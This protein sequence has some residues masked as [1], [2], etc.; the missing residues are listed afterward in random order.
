MQVFE[1]FRSL[2]GEGT[3]TG[4]PM[5]FVRVAG[6]DLACAYCDTSA[7]RDPA[8]GHAVSVEALVREMAA[9]P[10]PAVLITG[11]E[12][13]L[14]ADEV[15]R[16]A[17]ALLADGRE[18]LLETSGAHAVDLVAD[19]RVVRIVDF[20]T[21]G[22][23]MADRMCPRNVDL[24]TPRDEAKFVLTGRAD[25]E[26]ARTFVERHDLIGRTTVLFGAAAPALEPRTL[27]E[28]ILDDRLPVRLNVQLHKWLGL[29]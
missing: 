21:P 14:Q 29:P 22:S 6:C 4:L 10:L 17:A 11:G 5:W 2:Q 28:W 1:T 15:N 26:W 16:L 13:L 27:A 3:R 18:V 19:P 7:A 9:A 12:P 8:A 25:Y 20:K 23:G 24:L